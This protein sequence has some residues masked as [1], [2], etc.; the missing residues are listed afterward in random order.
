MSYI[1]DWKCGALTDA[2]FRSLAAEENRRERAY[3]YA[4]DR[5]CEHCK[6]HKEN[7]CEKWD[8]SFEEVADE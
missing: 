3:P 2:E 1:S 4:N 7:G 6:H 8:C 5:D